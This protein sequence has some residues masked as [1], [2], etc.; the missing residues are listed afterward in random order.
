MFRRCGYALRRLE[1]NVSLVDPY[2]EQVRLVGS[3]CK[4]IFEVGAADGRDCKKYSELFPTAKLYAFEPVPESFEKVRQISISNPSIHALNMAL[5]DKP[6]TAEFH[7]SNWHDESSLLKPQATGSTADAYTASSKSIQ[8]TVD[9][10]DQ[11]CERES[12]SHI[13]LLKM[14][15]QGAELRILNGAERMLRS[16]S[17]DVIY[18]EVLFLE[19]YKQTG[20]FDQIMKLLVENN[21][22]LHNLYDLAHN[23][24][25]QLAHCDAIFIRNR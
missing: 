24:H 4:T 15:A 9:T 13:N 21:F 14:D 7:I 16:N 25:G 3:D 5:S 23:Q 2:L 8:V 10:I 19:F 22:S 12:I 17:I 6:G 20:R 1:K 18:T 11:V